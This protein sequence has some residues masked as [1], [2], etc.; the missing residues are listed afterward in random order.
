MKNYLRW[1]LVFV[2]AVLIWKLTTTP[3]FKVTQD[4]LLS[5]LISSG[6]HFIFFG[7]QGVLVF[8]ALPSSFL[9]VSASS[10]YG[11]IIELV[12]RGVPGR[13]ADPMDWILDTLGAI[14]FLAIIKKY[15]IHKS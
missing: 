7:I 1:V 14:I 12:Q 15:L 10:I 13:S 11:F 2:W 4:T 3:D 5:L 9:A 6:G 8:L